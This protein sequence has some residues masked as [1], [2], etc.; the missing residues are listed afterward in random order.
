VFTQVAAGWCLGCVET[1]TQNF[2][3]LKKIKLAGLVARMVERR[4][5]H[6][7]FVRRTEKKEHLED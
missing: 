6:R 7:T 5:G 2:C 3:V 4:D 1:E